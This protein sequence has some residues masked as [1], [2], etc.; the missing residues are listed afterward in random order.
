MSSV[1]YKRSIKCSMSLLDINGL[2][3]E[4]VHPRRD[5]KDIHLYFDLLQESALYLSSQYGFPI[6]SRFEID[7]F[8]L[9][10]CAI[11]PTCFTILRLPK[12]V[13]QTGRSF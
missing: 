9:G 10:W 1:K 13:P 12:P 8:H 5:L 2:L 11:F 6:I 3:T 4:S 7:V